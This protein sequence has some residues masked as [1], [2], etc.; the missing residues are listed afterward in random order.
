MNFKEM[1]NTIL[2]E[3]AIQESDGIELIDADKT[4]G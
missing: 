4:V 2:L 1:V 3:M